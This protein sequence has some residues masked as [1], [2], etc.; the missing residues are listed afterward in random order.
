MRIQFKKEIL[1]I[2]L[3]SMSLC[4]LSVGCS[5]NEKEDSN[6]K[7]DIVEDASQ[8]QDNVLEEDTEEE[9][10][11]GYQFSTE[12]SIEDYCHGY[13]I[14]SKMEGMLYGVIDIQGNE[15]IPLEYDAIEFYNK[16]EVEDKREEE[17]I[18]LVEYEGE[19]NLINDLNEIVNI[20]GIVSRNVI[21]P[22][23]GEADEEICYYYIQPLGKSIY[24]SFGKLIGEQS[25]I[26]FLN[27]DEQEVGKYESEY[28]IE[29]YFQL[30]SE[31]YIICEHK[32]VGSYYL[33][34][35]DKYNNVLWKEYSM[36][37]AEI[38]AYDDMVVLSIHLGGGYYDFY[39]MS[40]DGTWEQ[41]SN[42]YHDDIGI[43][44]GLDNDMW[45]TLGKNDDI[46]IY[47][48][49]NTYKLTYSDGTALYEER[50]FA[51][52]NIEHKYF[53]LKNANEEVYAIDVEGN[54]IAE[55]GVF[56]L[57]ENKAAPYFEGQSLYWDKVYAGDDALY[58]VRASN[59]GYDVYRFSAIE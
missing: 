29:D 18:F 45:F 17:V 11:N 12:Y 31:Y 39:S 42:Y 55:L 5:S 19:N 27:Q 7:K 15:V 37:K 6:V 43:H 9:L 13:F 3:L 21:A 33:Y 38:K 46:Y 26:V 44:K 51:V 10:K 35:C 50:Y 28:Y 23:L 49:N 14:V 30:T 48:S 54:M 53:F 34:L 24:D 58:I 20:N 16:D 4:F 40:I 41:T 52:D 47:K 36:E 1:W 25:K 22:Y 59:N 32:D 56:E 2:A 8:E 57:Y